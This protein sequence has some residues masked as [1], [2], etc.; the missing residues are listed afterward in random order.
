MFFDLILKKLFIYG[1]FSSN[2]SIILLMAHTDPA[3]IIPSKN[4][5]YNKGVLNILFVGENINNDK[6]NPPHVEK[7][8]G[9]VMIPD[10]NLPKK[11][12]IKFLFSPHF[13]K[14]SLDP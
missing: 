5:E 7:Q 6:T 2:H 4:H 11:L 9:Q 13:F 1:L 10:K 12:K 3:D 14:K 8:S